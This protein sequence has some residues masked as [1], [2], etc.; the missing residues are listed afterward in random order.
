MQSKLENVELFHCEGDILNEPKMRGDK[1][2][3]RQAA[4]PREAQEK[5]VMEEVD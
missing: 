2:E 1:T 3:P 5:K 4:S